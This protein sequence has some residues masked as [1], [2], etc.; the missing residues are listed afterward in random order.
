MGCVPFYIK[1]LY[2]YIS[3]IPITDIEVTRHPENH[4]F[5]G[6]VATVD[7][8]GRWDFVVLKTVVF[9]K[10][11]KKTWF[12]ASEKMDLLTWKLLFQ[13][14]GH[15]DVVATGDSRGRWNF[16]VLKTVVFAEPCKKSCFFG[17]RQDGLAN[18]EIVVSTVWEL[19]RCC[20][21]GRRGK[22]DLR[23][24]KNGCFCKTL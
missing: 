4:G 3:E 9:A 6:V 17:F 19:Q 16:V 23:R 8:R 7:A 1:V 13:L 15:Y 22:M 10:P 11:C 2:S 14:Y 21:G 18:M 5:C 24:A 12:L 20:D